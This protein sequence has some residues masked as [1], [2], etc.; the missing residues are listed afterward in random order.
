VNVTVNPSELVELCLRLS[1][2]P[3]SW[4]F[5]YLA[6]PW[7]N[8]VKICCAQYLCVYS[9]VSWGVELLL[10]HIAVSAILRTGQPLHR[11]AGILIPKCLANASP[12]KA[13]ASIKNSCNWVESL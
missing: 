1:L 3:L 13:T 2:M 8:V 9:V 10:V 12:W 7:F 5:A 11:R 4:W 6:G